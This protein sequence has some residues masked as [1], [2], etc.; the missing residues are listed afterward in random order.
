MSEEENKFLNASQGPVVSS[1]GIKLP[2]TIRLDGEVID[3]FKDRAKKTG[4]KAKY[5]TLINEALKEYIT[6]TNI[7]D[8]LLSDDFVKKL[9]QGIKKA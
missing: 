1:N 4:G 8:V 3:Y 7:R 6:A 2:V 9:S 5:Q